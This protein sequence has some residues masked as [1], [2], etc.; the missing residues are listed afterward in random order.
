MGRK[1]FSEEIEKGSAART[2]GHAL[3]PVV[4]VAHVEYS[5][6]GAFLKT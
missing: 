6:L 1:G 3:E 4:E 5:T 2:Y